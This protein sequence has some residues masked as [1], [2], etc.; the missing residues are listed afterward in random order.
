MEPRFE[1]DTIMQMFIAGE[2]D[3][4]MELPVTTFGEGIVYLMAAYYVFNVE[5]P[6]PYKP[7]LFFFKI[8]SWIKQTTAKGQQDMP[9]LP[10][11]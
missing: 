1:D 9:H 6:N 4:L 5:Y 8:L 7:L 2:D 3:N 10:P 11:Q